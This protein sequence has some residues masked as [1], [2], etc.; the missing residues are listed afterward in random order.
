MNYLLQ[1]Y[2]DFA[3]P[4]N[5]LDAILVI[6]HVSDHRDE[7]EVANTWTNLITQGKCIPSPPRDKDAQHADRNPPLL[8]STKSHNVACRNCGCVVKQ[9]YHTHST[10]LSIRRRATS[11]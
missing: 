2:A 10:L 6:F 5:L 1:L 9:D 4:L 7:E 8:S 3:Q 11:S